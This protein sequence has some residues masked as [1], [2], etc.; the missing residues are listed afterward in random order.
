MQASQDAP[1]SR[2]TLIHLEQLLSMLEAGAGGE[3]H[4]KQKAQAKIEAGGDVAKDTLDMRNAA[5]R[6]IFGYPR[7]DGTDVSDEFTRYSAQQVR[8]E[9]SKW[10]VEFTR[11]VCLDVQHSAVPFLRFPQLLTYIDSC[12]RQFRF[13]PDVVH[14]MGKDGSS[15]VGNQGEEMCRIHSFVYLQA[16]RSICTSGTSSISR[17]TQHQHQGCS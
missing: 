9:C 2:E 13:E 5:V 11:A 12:A 4:G 6:F 1:R 8:D 3:R 7:G 17:R 10:M 14:E 15:G 16:C